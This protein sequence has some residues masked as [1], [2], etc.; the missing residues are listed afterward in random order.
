[1]AVAKYAN[2]EIIN[3]PRGKF[4][5]RPNEVGDHIE[6]PGYGW[7]K[8]IKIQSAHRGMLVELASRGPDLPRQHWP[9]WEIAKQGNKL[10]EYNLA[11]GRTRPL[12][13]NECSPA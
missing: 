1:M 5:G 6:L 3:V 7:G 10:L 12:A 11:H 9:E 8:V 2:G 4:G 13:G